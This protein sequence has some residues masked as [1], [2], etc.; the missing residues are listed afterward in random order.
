MKISALDE[1]GNPVDWW[2]I[3]KVPQ[4]GAG[5]GTDSA[6]GYE[7]VYYDSKI[8]ANPDLKQ[9]NVAKSP[10][11]LNGG[12]GALNLTLYSVFSNP[13]PLPPSTGYILYNDEMPESVGKTD[14]GN[15]G[16]TKGV[17]AFDTATNTGF[18]LLHSWPK[19][20]DPGAKGDPTPEY[21]QTYLCISLDVPTCNKIAAI[22]ATHQEPQI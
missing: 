18:W 3:Y 8:D 22:M 1:T 17:I 20:A 11:L 10:N 14:D 5:A 4:L 6:T 7:Y 16:H 12:K 21:G 2:F 9:R 15:K 13:T 19:F